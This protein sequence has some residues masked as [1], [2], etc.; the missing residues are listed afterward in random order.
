MV[1]I[2]WFAS[3]FPSI[4]ESTVA[5]SGCM[6][7]TN[8]IVHLSLWYKMLKKKDISKRNDL[9]DINKKSSNWFFFS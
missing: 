4:H 7:I 5:D 3:V 1:W 8:S 9:A 6:Q 2:Y